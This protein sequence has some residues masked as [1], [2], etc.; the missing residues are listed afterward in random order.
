MFLVLRLS[1]IGNVVLRV[2]RFRYRYRSDLGEAQVQDVGVQFV[3]SSGEAVP[4]QV[5]PTELAAEQNKVGSDG[6]R[7]DIPTAPARR[8]PHLLQ[9]FLG[10]LTSR[11]CDRMVMSCVM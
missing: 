8:S 9:S 11:M 1:V 3:Q 4:V 7:S 5:V 2:L 6:G 10:K